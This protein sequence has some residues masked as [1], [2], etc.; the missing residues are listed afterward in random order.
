MNKLERWLPFKFRRKSKEE[1]QSE[2]ARDT[3]R[4]VAIA[5]SL[6]S[7]FRRSPFSSPG[8]NQLMQSFFNDPFFRDPFGHLRE[9]DRWF[10]DFSPARFQPTVDVVDEE[11]ALC[12][13]AE[14]PGMSKDDVQ[15]QIE[16]DMLVIRGEKKHEEEKKEKGIYRGERY[17]GYFERTVPLPSELD[18]EKA[19]AQF[20]KGVLRIRLPKRP[21]EIEKGRKIQIK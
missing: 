20:D 13:T 3:G 15:L 21:R 14:L 7:Y 9:L 2:T 19:E 16:G 10:G 1:K 17:Y 5:T 12:V 6:P 8:M 11:D 4:D 18:Q